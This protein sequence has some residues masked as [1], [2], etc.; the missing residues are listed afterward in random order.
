MTCEEQAGMVYS[1]RKSKA[2]CWLKIEDDIATIEDASH[3]SGMTTWEVE[4]TLK[5]MV[6]AYL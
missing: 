5:N 4:K 3:M 6:N 1:L 2:L